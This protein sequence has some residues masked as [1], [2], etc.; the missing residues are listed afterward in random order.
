VSASIVEGLVSI[1]IPVHDR[2]ELLREAVAS[3]LAQTH[4]PLEILIVDDGSTDQ[5]GAACDAIANERPAVVRAFHR[6]N[7]GPGLARET[8]RAAARGEFLQYLDSDDLMLPRKLERQVAALRSSGADVAYCRT[9]EYRLGEPPA[10][11][12]SQRT[13]ERFERLFPELLSGPLWPTL[14]PLFRRSLTDAIGPWSALRVEEDWEYDARAGALGA[15]R[16]YC[17]ETLAD[18]RNHQGSRASGHRG[19]AHMAMRAEAHR[20]IH[21]HAVRAGVTP[22]EPMMQRYARELFLLS[23]Q[24][25]AAGLAEEARDLFALSRSASGSRR[26]RGADFLL[27]SLA[28]RLVGWEAT[29]RASCWADRVRSGQRASA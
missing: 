19:L 6:A 13:G 4:R 17:D 9:R 2:A 16:V 8:G 26:A 27:Y 1:V 3:A 11:T 7:G 22:D 24:C 29:G 25:G 12:A 21:A 28:A 18:V 23:R 10:D 5:T 20:R 15:R 14:S